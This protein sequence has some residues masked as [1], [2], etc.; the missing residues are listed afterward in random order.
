MNNGVEVPDDLREE[1]EDLIIDN[2]T[3]QAKYL[4]FCQSIHEEQ[5]RLVVRSKT[6]WAEAMSTM[7][8]QGEWHYHNG[9]IYP[10]DKIR[11]N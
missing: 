4:N 11:D 7:G 1:F 8:L 3:L 9:M 10:V 2:A 5:R 6:V